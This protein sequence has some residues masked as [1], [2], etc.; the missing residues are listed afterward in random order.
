MYVSPLAH[1]GGSFAQAR[2]HEVWRVE[3]HARL[4]ADV[5]TFLG[6]TVNVD[7]NVVVRL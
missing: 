3:V 2:L 1:T 5:H 7:L 6:Q 4:S